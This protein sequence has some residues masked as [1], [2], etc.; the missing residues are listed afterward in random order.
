MKK[1]QIYKKIINPQCVDLLF[2]LSEKEIEN[3]TSILSC[4]YFN[5]DKY[6]TKLFEVLVKQIRHLKTGYTN[7]LKISIY[8]Q[9]FNPKRKLADLNKKEDNLLRAK[10]S[11]L[12]QIILRCLSIEELS[13]YKAYEDD[14]ILKTLI[15]R[16]LF[17]LLRQRAKRSKKELLKLEH[18]SSEFHKHY[19]V[20]E[21]NVQ[22]MNRFAGK[23]L[24]NENLQELNKHL[25][26]N[27]LVDKL[28]THITLLSV[29]DTSLNQYDFSSMDAVQDLLNLDPYQNH[30]TIKLY[31]VAVELMKTPVEKKYKQLLD[32]LSEY[33]NQLPKTEIESLYDI[34]TN[35]CTIQIRKGNFD[36]K[37]LFELY[38]L[39]H[40]NQ[41]LIR[42]DY[43]NE[44]T[45]KNIVTVS[46]HTK[47]FKWATELIETCFQYLRKSVRVSVQNFNL[48]TLAFYQK[49]YDKAHNF[50][51]KVQ[52][53][54]INYDINNR[55][56]LAKTFYETD[57]SYDWPTFTHF[58]SEQRYFE[59]TKQLKSSTG[60]AYKNFFVILKDLY[61]IKHGAINKKT[62]QL[63]NK[64]NKM[65][66]V[67]TRDWL[68]EKIEELKSGK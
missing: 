57:K 54:N 28:K 49:Q 17:K 67:A 37:N 11:D 32:L 8:N 55:L 20:L 64:L 12:T 14:L 7:S 30:L 48:G 42:D 25:D 16:K 15:H 59:K 41:F 45:L 40:A 60:K 4:S 53:V 31:A 21:E 38:Q 27:Y 65:N 13:K 9:V 34:A 35:F 44:N 39:M 18:R 22:I 33:S 24:Y 62:E 23:P 58:N 19:F 5:T 50:F 63:E 1:D 36:Y 10:Y 68:I 2:S 51:S 66:N 56:M 3:C 6:V 52:D 26:I 46:Y 29:Q 43:I 61:K 47:Q